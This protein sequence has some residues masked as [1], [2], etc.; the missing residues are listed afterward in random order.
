[1]A[2]SSQTL[3]LGFL[4]VLHEASGHLGGYLVTNIWGRPLEFRLSTAVQPNRVQQILYGETLEAYVCADLIGKTLVDKTATQ[5]QLLVTDTQAALDLRLRVKVPVIFLA[6]KDADAKPADTIRPG[7][8]ASGPLLRHSRFPADAAQVSDMLAR[9][10]GSLDLAE[11]FARIREAITEA[12]RM[13]VT[14]RN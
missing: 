8:A 4:T 9:L 12:R 10:E 5:V 7:D 1:M 14:G 11:P 13:G 2:Q 3:N 6:A